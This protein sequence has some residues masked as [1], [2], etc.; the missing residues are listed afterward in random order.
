MDTL[1][2][3][4]EKQHQAYMAHRQVQ[5]DRSRDYIAWFAEQNNWS[6]EE[7]EMVTK[8]LGLDEEG[9]WISDIP[10]WS[11]SNSLPK[12]GRPPKAKLR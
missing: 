11:L 6:P 7:A 12:G 9:K 5:R 3:I 10:H 4:H 2:E 8:M 1:R